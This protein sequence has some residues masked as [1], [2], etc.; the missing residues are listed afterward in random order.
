LLDKDRLRLQAR[1]SSPFL[2]I[3]TQRNGIKRLIINVTIYRTPLILL[4]FY[5]IIA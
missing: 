3:N 1:R 2:R 4:A 5:T